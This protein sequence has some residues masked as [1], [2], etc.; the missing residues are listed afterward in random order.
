[1]EKVKS[2]RELTEK[3]FNTLKKSGLLKTIHPDSP[4]TYK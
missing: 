3:E 1:M 2:L 4:Y